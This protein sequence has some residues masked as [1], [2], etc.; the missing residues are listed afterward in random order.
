MTRPSW[1]HINSVARGRWVE[2]LAA[3]GIPA[4]RLDGRGHACPRCGGSDRFSAFENIQQRGAV[5]CRHC[6]TSGSSIRP[7]NG[8]ATL[9]WWAGGTFTSTLDWLSDHLGVGEASGSG[10]NRD[11]IGASG[12][13]T[14]QPAKPRESTAAEVRRM[15]QLTSHAMRC[16]TAVQFHELS[17]HLGISESSLRSLCVGYSTDYQATTWPMRNSQGDVVGIR[18]RSTVDDKKWSVRGSRSG[19]FLSRNHRPDGERVFIVEG[20]SDLAA[21]LDLEIACI[22][23]PSCCGGTHQIGQYLARVGYRQ[24][25][26]IADR[27]E[28]G[29]AGAMSLAKRLS[30]RGVTTSVV[31]V[32]DHAKDLR[33]WRQ[34]GATKTDVQTLDVIQH[35]AARPISEQLN[36]DFAA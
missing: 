21:A 26:I 14:H 34:K 25:T 6:F 29:I 1:S 17:N 20:P 24:A 19:L 2:I 12:S 5:H 15:T 28:A 30:M 22:G 27:D 36:F 18:L 16:I 3:A 10:H 32:A 4:D 23:R 33:Q 8:I 35:F 7:G 11:W 31:T 13:P 9:M